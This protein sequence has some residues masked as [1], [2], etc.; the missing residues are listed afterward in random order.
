MFKFWVTCQDNLTMD[1]MFLLQ[2]IEQLVYGA[3]VISVH[4]TVVQS[5]FHIDFW[6]F[7]RKTHGIK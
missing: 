2:L 4:A 5:N 7:Y 3:D 6:C 1:E